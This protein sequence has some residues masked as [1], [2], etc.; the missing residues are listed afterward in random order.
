MSGK[1]ISI[2]IVDDEPEARE[3]LIL[4][5]ERI[6]GVELAG[7]AEGVDDAF[8]FIVGK[9]PDLVLLDIQMPVRNGFELV[10]MV[11]EE[12]MDTGF[13]FVTAFDEYAIEAIRSS[14]FD[15]LLKPVDTADLQK[16]I[17]RFRELLKVTDIRHQLGEMLRGLSSKSKIKVNTRAGFILINPEEVVY[18]SAAGNYTEVYLVN[19]RVEVITSHLGSFVEQLPPGSF[20]RISRSVMINLNYLT[21]V[22]HKAGTCRLKGDSVIELKV[23]RNRR[24]ELDESFF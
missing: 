7:T 1:N 16:A 12:G 10:R 5:L 2:L 9:D 6:V 15:Y 17:S 22:D 19:S 20:F 18:C 13:I 4:L 21:R 3:L 11:H 14:A 24:R 8:A 23:A